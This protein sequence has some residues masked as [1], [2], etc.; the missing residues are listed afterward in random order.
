MKI[1][2]SLLLYCFKA[3]NVYEF[4]RRVKILAL[5][6]RRKCDKMLIET[7]FKRNNVAFGDILK[8]V[9]FK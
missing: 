5:Y 3:Y 2:K 4:E 8:G 6:I 7:M 1:K 9:D